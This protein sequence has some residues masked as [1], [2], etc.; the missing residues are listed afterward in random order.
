MGLLGRPCAVVTNCIL[1]GH[2]VEAKS[3]GND[4]ESL[5]CCRDPLCSQALVLRGIASGSYRML[6]QRL[7]AGCIG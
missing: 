3:N 6:H 2:G 4:E 7:L 5:V 1:G